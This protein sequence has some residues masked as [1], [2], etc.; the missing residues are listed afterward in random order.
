MAVTGSD[1]VAESA[2]RAGLDTSMSS[3][4]YV[5][6]VGASSG[7]VTTSGTAPAAYDSFSGAPLGEVTVEGDKAGIK[8]EFK[9]ELDKAIT[10]YIDNLNTILDGLTGEGIDIG[11][12]FKGTNVETAVQNLITAVKDEAL[13]YTTSLKDAELEVIDLVD[14]AYA[15]NDESISSSMNADTGALGG[16]TSA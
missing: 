10:G 6:A 15:S 9:S 7:N 2:K 3:T 11:Q 8:E 12:A 13:R 1:T 16:G 14:K 5:E 4:G